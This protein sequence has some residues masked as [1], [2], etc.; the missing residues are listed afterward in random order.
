MKRVHPRPVQVDVHWLG[1]ESAAPLDETFQL[2]VWYPCKVFIAVGKCAD[3]ARRHRYLAKLVRHTNNNPSLVQ[4]FDLHHL[5]RK[6]CTLF[7]VGQNRA[8]LKVS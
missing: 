2:Q 7:P 4:K 1:T 6:F 5:S 8:R 3:G